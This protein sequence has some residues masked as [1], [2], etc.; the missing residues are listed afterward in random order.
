MK[1]LVL[2]NFFIHCNTLHIFNTFDSVFVRHYTYI[3]YSFSTNIHSN[4]W[5]SRTLKGRELYWKLE[6]T[7]EQCCLIYDI[8][9]ILKAQNFQHCRTKTADIFFAFVLLKLQV[10]IHYHYV[11][12]SMSCKMF[13]FSAGIYLCIYQWISYIKSFWQLKTV[14]KYYNNPRKKT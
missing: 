2:F 4:N 5:K 6:T 9:L 8:Q 12:D 7:E 10:V 13:I 14:K 11:Q 1:R 3:L